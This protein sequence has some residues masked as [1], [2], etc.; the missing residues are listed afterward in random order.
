MSYQKYGDELIMQCP[1][2]K[3]INLIIA[4]TQYDDGKLHSNITCHDCGHSF[5]LCPKCGSQMIKR[6][7]KWH[8]TVCRFFIK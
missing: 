8:C 3:S 7:K 4:T 2:C 5:E 6:E 1:K